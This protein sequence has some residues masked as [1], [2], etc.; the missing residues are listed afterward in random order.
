MEEKHKAE[1]E[2]FEL[3]GADRYNHFGTIDGKPYT[4]IEQILGM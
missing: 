2:R 4:E 1:N 3:F